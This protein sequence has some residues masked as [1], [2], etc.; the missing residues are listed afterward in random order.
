MVLV[1]DMPSELALQMYEVSLE[2]LLW[3]P[4]YLADKIL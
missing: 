1:H 2:Y 3:F 4:S